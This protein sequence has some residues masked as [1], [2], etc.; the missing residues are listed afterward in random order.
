MSWVD[1]IKDSLPEYA[2]D[3]KLN[4]D[5][6]VNR[7]TIDPEQATYLAIAAAFATGNGKLLAFITSNATDEVEK[8]AALTAGS[9]MAQ[10][11]VWYPYVE[12]ADDPALTGLPAQLR[13]NAIASHGGT[14][15][16]KFEA[17]SLASSIV[18][19]CH[20]CVKAHY[21]TLKQEGYTV[22]QLRDI[23]RIAA[24]INALSKVLSA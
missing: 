2:K 4:L 13:M 15:K 14:T 23:G 7:S 9:L 18:G 6:V 17:Y 10:N 8:N 16:A 22:E 21:E 11:N 12:M 5:A 19:K 24:T 20:F 1:Q 3:I